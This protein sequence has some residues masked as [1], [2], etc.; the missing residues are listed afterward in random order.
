M[1]LVEATRRHWLIREHFAWPI[2]RGHGEELRDIV[3]PL[4]RESA[5][6]K[7]VPVRAEV[8]SRRVLSRYRGAL[9][10]MELHRAWRPLPLWVAT[11]VPPDRCDLQSQ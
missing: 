11:W 1:L 10:G 3:L 6:T 4:L 2:G 8:I 9:A 5:T 7:G